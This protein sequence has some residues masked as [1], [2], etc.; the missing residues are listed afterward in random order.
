M[1]RMVYCSGAV[2]CNF[3]FALFVVVQS[4]SH[5]QLFATPWT[6]ECLASLSFT[7]YWSLLRL[8]S[9]ESVMSSN[10]L[11]LCLPLLF[12]PSIFPSIRVFELK[13]S[14]EKIHSRSA[15]SRNSTLTWS[16]HLIL[17]YG[18]VLLLFIWNDHNVNLLWRSEVKWSR[19]VVSDSLR[20]HG[21]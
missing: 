16:D 1:F 5:V 3:F 8:M 12:L 10:H 9:I 6:E 18:Q 15:F 2:I 20:P 14:E 19:S 7:I 17:P 13:L 11:V 21:L 4:L